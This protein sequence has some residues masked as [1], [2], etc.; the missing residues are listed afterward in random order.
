MLDVADEVG[1][2]EVDAA[3][4]WDGARDALGNLDAVT[5]PGGK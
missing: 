2:E 1:E 4:V 5:L 3:L